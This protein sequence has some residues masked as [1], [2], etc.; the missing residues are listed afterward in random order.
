MDAEDF[1]VMEG[2]FKHYVGILSEDF[3]HKL[4]IVVDGHQMLSDKFDR[5]EDKVDRLE[6]RVCRVEVKVDRIAV[7][8]DAHRAD[9]EAHHGAY[10]VRESS[11]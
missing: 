6:E 11:D 9:T 8:L 1:K 2:M 7:E 5:L 10:C 3:Q 4:D